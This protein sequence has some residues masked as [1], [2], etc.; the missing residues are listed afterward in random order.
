MRKLCR[1]DV[2]AMLDRH[3]RYMEIASAMSEQMAAAAGWS[4]R[5]QSALEEGSIKPAETP[6]V[7]RVLTRY[8]LSAAERNA[9]LKSQEL[10]E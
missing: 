8:D 5:L 1:K 3:A 7:V 6:R 2:A 9:L 4:D 10:S